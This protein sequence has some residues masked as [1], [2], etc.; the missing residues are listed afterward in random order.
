MNK[1]SYLTILLV[2]CLVFSCGSDS[3]KRV[4]EEYDEDLEMVE[5]DED[6]T[7]ASKAARK[8]ESHIAK[9]EKNISDIQ[10][11][12]DRWF[13]AVQTQNSAGDAIEPSEIS[14]KV[15][16]F[17]KDL[18]KQQKNLDKVDGMITDAGLLKQPFS[19]DIKDISYKIEAL[20]EALDKF[21]SQYQESYDKPRI[22]KEEIKKQ[23]EKNSE[24]VTKSASEGKTCY[25]I[26][27]TKK[28]LKE[29][30]LNNKDFLNSSGLHSYSSELNYFT[31]SGINNLRTIQLGS[32]KAKILTSQGK[33][34]SYL[35]S[36]NPDG[37]KV[38]EILDPDEFWRQ[39]N[40]LVVQID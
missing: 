27:A 12:I 1:L 13:T 30:K 28:E 20:N 40:F 18:N 38:L 17:K 19:K 31:P 22:E 5:D 32:K 21:D 6:E 14:K 24:K 8:I 15:A 29:H 3:Q 36:E 23:V 34:S 35:I 26:V 9:V 16:D 37:T 39:Q 10:T 7:K 11:Q 25:Y 4:V 2:S 33:G